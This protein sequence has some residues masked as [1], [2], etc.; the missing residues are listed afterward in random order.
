MLKSA[1]E[2]RWINHSETCTFEDRHVKDPFKFDPNRFL[3]S[4]G[5][6]KRNKNMLGPFGFGKRS[7]P[8]QAIAELQILLYTVN[9]LR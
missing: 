9:L 5:G 2:P 8:G 4:N 7:C 3:D 6:L 1:T